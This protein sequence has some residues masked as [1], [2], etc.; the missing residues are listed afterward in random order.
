MENHDELCPPKCKHDE[1]RQHAFDLLCELVTGSNENCMVVIEL[2][3]EQLQATASNSEKTWNYSPKFAQK[4]SC[5]YVGL[6]NLGATCYMN[7]IMQQFF[8]IPS[9]RAGILSAKASETADTDSTLLQQLQIMFS[10][11]QESVRKAYD[12]YPFCNSYKDFDGNP[13]NVAV[14]MD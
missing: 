2:L 13:M 1:T 8:M 6:K 5:G 10:Y 12:T 4:S 3:F 11:L 7:S 14:Q 9:F